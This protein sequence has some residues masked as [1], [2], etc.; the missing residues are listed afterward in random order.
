[1][2]PQEL[3]EGIT[4]YVKAQVCIDILF[5]YSR[6]DYEKLYLTTAAQF[7]LYPV[8]QSHQVISESDRGQAGKDGP[9][10]G[11]IGTIERDDDGLEHAESEDSGSLKGLGTSVSGSDKECQTILD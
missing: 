8:S 2:T 5:I 1:M 6:R 3:R 9:A 10:A 4:G 7:I 11:P